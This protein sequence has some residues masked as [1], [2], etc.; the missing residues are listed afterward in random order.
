MRNETLNAQSKQAHSVLVPD[1]RDLAIIPFGICILVRRHVS[2]VVI[3]RFHVGSARMRWRRCTLDYLDNDG[4]L[5]FFE[6]EDFLVIW[7]ISN[8]AVFSLVSLD[9]SAY[10][11]PRH[12]SK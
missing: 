8:C 2:V 9:N 6:D 11:H 10:S 1:I 7:D 12:V 5:T 4:A 3:Q